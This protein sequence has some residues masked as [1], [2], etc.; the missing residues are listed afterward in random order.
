MVRWIRRASQTVSVKMRSGFEDTGL[1]RANLAAIEAAGASFVTIHPRTKVQGYKGRADW[2][3]IRT[4]KETLT[5]PVVGNGDVTSAALA[6]ALFAETGCDG[7]MVGRGAVQDPM[8]FRNIRAALGGAAGA[9]AGQPGALGVGDD[10][11]LIC[12]FVRRYAD[13][14]AGDGPG[15]AKSERG[16]FNK[17]KQV[18]SYLLSSTPTLRA[19]LAP[20]LQAQVATMSMEELTQ[21]IV[22]VVRAEWS[23]RDLDPRQVQSVLH[24]RQDKEVLD[25][26]A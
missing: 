1:F 15:S 17:L 10:V 19:A 6:Q 23:R 11:E 18:T 21:Q 2:S 26:V 4:A 8:I 24:R 20:I 5:I 13:E 9:E 7:I 25:G 22:D 12:A 14:V 16:Q 3:L